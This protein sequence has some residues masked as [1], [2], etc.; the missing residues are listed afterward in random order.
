MRLLCATLLLALSLSG[1]ALTRERR[2]DAGSRDAALPDVLDAF[3]IRAGTIT[4]CTEY[5]TM[6]S[7]CP[8]I[9]SEAIGTACREEG[10]RCGAGCCEPG[11]AIT[12][13]GGR[14]V[15][16]GDPDCRGVRCGPNPTCGRGSCAQGRVCLHPSIETP[17]PD[18]CVL[19][20]A[21]MNTCSAAPAG[22]I[23]TDGCNQCNCINGEGI[24][25]ITLECACCD[26][27]H[28]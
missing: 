9:P 3:V 21:P 10:V 13:T 20:R 11:P 17:L 25:E 7:A 18:Q 2:D 1:C 19:P 24:P 14:W 26:T 8:A 4:N 12:C 22:A 5:W 27:A 16:G 15:P 23:A 6:L 28:P